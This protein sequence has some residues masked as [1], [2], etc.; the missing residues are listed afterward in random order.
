MV[1]YS[2]LFMLVC[3]G[4]LGRSKELCYTADVRKIA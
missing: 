3:F 4:T 1:C 2:H